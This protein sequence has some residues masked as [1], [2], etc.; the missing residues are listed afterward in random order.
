MP[1]QIISSSQCGDLFLYIYSFFVMRMGNIHLSIYLSFLIFPIYL[2]IYLSICL[3]TY[4]SIHPSV[5]PSIHLYI[6][7]AVKWKGR[8][9]WVRCMYAYLH[10]VEFDKHWVHMV[11]LYFGC[12]V[13]PLIRQLFSPWGSKMQYARKNKAHFVPKPN[14]WNPKGHI[15]LR[16]P[17]SC[18]NGH[19]IHKSSLS[20]RTQPF[21]SLFFNH[22]AK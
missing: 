2:S 1:V 18:L 10:G 15:M 17:L 11:H 14:S 4:L 12:R 20:L 13:D 19:K 16:H 8:T 9:R 21:D 3:P 7:D 5:R 6:S 22:P